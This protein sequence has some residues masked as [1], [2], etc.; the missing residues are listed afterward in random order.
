MAEVV[1]ASAVGG[2]FDVPGYSLDVV[3]E[4]RFP[5]VPSDRP[6]SGCRLVGHS[7]GGGVAVRLGATDAS[8]VAAVHRDHRQVGRPFRGERLQDGEE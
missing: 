5:A 1:T 3:G 8:L 7:R 4:R 6:L 2:Y